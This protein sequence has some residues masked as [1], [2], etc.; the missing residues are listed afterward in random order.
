MD[1][2]EKSLRTEEKR[3]PKFTEKMNHWK[4]I[5]NSKLA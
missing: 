2:A 4:V 3:N 5:V 1:G